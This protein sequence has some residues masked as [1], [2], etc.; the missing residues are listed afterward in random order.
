M[1]RMRV[2]VSVSVSVSVC[3]RGTCVYMCT[4]ELYK[5]PLQRQ[6]GWNCNT[7]ACV[8]LHA[9]PTQIVIVQDTGWRRL[10]GSLICIG[11]FLQKWP[12]LIGS[13][14]ENDLQLRGSYES[15]PP[16]I[17]RVYIPNDNVFFDNGLHRVCVQEVAY[18]YR[19][20]KI[21]LAIYCG[22]VI[23]THRDITKQDSSYGRD[24]RLCGFWC[25]SVLLSNS[26]TQIGIVH[27]ITGCE[28]QVVC[29]VY[30]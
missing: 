18:G 24:T 30:I 6:H 29:S 5:I 20:Q 10:I 1:R 7:C 27:H 22:W 23:L 12:I 3:V 28:I 4:H 9:R 8:C 17:S 16:C 15:S 11:H 26:R 21:S 14:V 19:K 25:C 13:F 2:R